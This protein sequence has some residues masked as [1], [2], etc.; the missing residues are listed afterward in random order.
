M[1]WIFH[2]NQSWP[3]SSLWQE[4]WSSGFPSTIPPPWIYCIPQLDSILHTADISPTSDQYDPSLSD[5]ACLDVK[6]EYRTSNL[7]L[8]WIC[9]TSHLYQCFF[10]LKA[11]HRCE[12]DVPSSSDDSR[13]GPY[14]TGG[15]YSPVCS[16][17]I[18]VGG[19]LIIPI[20]QD[21]EQ[22]GRWETEFLYFWNYIRLHALVQLRGQVYLHHVTC[23]I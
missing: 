2:M 20:L 4:F 19:L 8:K 11:V 1:I 10:C 9:I 16:I 14:G 3:P 12:S 17:C 6:S 5:L 13:G 22:E 18:C 21:W 7:F 15:K 23:Y